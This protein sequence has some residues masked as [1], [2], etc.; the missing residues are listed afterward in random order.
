VFEQAVEHRAN[1]GWPG[2][3]G[4]VGGDGARS[5][6]AVIDDL[7]GC[8]SEP[9]RYTRLSMAG[10]TPVGGGARDA[11]KCCGMHSGQRGGRG[12]LFH[13]RSMAALGQGWRAAVGYVG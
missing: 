1:F 3:G 9:K 6:G 4:E 13:T 2:V 11:P 12:G 5:A 7:G 8:R 10:S